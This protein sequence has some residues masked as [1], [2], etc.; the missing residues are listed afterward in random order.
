LEGVGV[1]ALAQDRLNEA[2]GL[3]IGARRVGPRPQVAQLG[4]GAGLAKEAD[5]IGRAVVGHDAL[6]DDA[7]SGEPGESPREKATALSLRSSGRI[8]V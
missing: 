4:G 2:L 7:V 6:G 5:A 1:G 8:S 3:A